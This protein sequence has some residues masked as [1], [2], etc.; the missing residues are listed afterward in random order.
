MYVIIFI[1]SGEVENITGIL[2]GEDFHWT[3][4]MIGLGTYRWAS[5]V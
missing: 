5:D 1:S 4:H 3:R 2:S